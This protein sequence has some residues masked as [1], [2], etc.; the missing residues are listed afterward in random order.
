MPLNNRAVRAW[1]LLPLAV[2]LTACGATSPRL[3]S[4]V[5]PLPPAARQEPAPE[6]CLPTCSDGWRRLVESLLPRPTEPEPPGLPA[7][8]P[9]TH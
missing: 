2:L 4:S 6:T 1:T 7:S 3:P 5:P 8:A 9:M